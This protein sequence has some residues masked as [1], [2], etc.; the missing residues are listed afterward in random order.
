MS[1]NSNK[2]KLIDSAIYLF[3]KKGYTETSVQDIVERAEVTKGSFYYYFNAK[4]D[5]LYLI[6]DRFIDYELKRVTE[7][8]NTPGLSCTE[9]LKRMMLA[10]WESIALYRDEV[11]IYLHER[12][13]IVGEK[14]ELIRKK[15]DQFENC[16]VSVL[17]EGV[18]NGEFDPSINP[19]LI[20]FSILG[21]SGW[22]IYW[23]RQS[24][25]L[26]I[27]EIAEMHQNLVLHGI[28]N[29]SVD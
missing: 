14:Y 28:S 12:R 29:K 18:K 17:E 25:S 16:F 4:D 13:H 15:R 6:H 11:E 19:K 22:A 9:K 27:E 20:T 21:M 24:G 23:Y 3:A 26:S 8:I 5:L 10:T 2:Q 7:I 1:A